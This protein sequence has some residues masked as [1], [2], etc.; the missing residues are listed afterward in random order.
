M[1]INLVSITYLQIVKLLMEIKNNPERFTLLR[2][3][4]VYK[5]I[6]IPYIIF[7]IHC[8]ASCDSST[9]IMIA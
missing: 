6:C 5:K 8:T 7:L 4:K 9:L 1:S 2:A 3:I